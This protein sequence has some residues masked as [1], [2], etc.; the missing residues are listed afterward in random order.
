[1]SACT[2]VVDQDDVPVPDRRQMGN[3]LAASGPVAGADRHLLLRL[4]GAGHPAADQEDREAVHCGYDKAA[5]IADA[6]H[7][8]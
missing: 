3:R 8:S 5:A 1:M 6:V 4:R 7:L 2:G